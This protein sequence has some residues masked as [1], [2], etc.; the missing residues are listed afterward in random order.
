MHMH[1]HM[2]AYKQEQQKT[3]GFSINYTRT[4][5]SWVLMSRVGVTRGGTK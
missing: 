2:H 4:E 3:R 1:A 5:I